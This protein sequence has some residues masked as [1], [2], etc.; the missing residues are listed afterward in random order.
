VTPDIVPSDGFS[1]ADLLKKASTAEEARQAADGL[2]AAKLSEF[3]P[4]PLPST[5]ADATVWEAGPSSIAELVL[6]PSQIR[7]L[8]ASSLLP[9]SPGSTPAH[10]YRVVL[11]RAGRGW[12]KNFCAAHIVNRVAQEAARLVAEGKLQR[13]SARILLVGRSADDVNSAMIGGPT[14]LVATS[15]E[16]FRAEHQPGNRRVV[17]GGG[18]VE[19]VARSAQEPEGVR[20]Q[21]AIFCWAD[22]LCAWGAGLEAT[23]ANL[24]LA[25]RIGPAP[26]VLV[27]TT[28]KPSDFLRGL[29]V[30]S[31]TLDI[32]R[33][34]SDNVLALGQKYVADK[35]AEY[36]GWRAAQELDALVLDGAAQ[37]FFPR[38]DVRFLESVPE[39]TR[40]VRAWDLAATPPSY[41]NPDP[42]WTCGIKLGRTTA[43]QFV[44][45]HAVMLRDRP[46]AVEQ[47]ILR[48]A[49][50]DGRGVPIV[51]P[52]DPGQAGVAQVADLVAK[53]AG[54]V[55]RTERPTGS[56]ATRAEP[57]SIQWCHGN[58]K[59]IRASWND[60]YL[61]QMEAFSSD[62]S[63][64]HDDA[65][66]A[67]A[68][69]FNFLAAERPQP[70][71]IGGR[72]GGQ[73]RTDAGMPTRRRSRW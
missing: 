2:R 16:W 29:L 41:T 13:E 56:K 67:S 60:D 69:A 11:L 22:E 35:Y 64:G 62:G 70:N 6:R 31:D 73:R 63:P 5:Y 26:R 10:S 39:I 1:I 46:A 53:L 15:P 44:I 58:V 54:H 3:C 24:D 40:V 27:S 49:E 61:R 9:P 42:D 18:L 65:P 4:A 17:W 23:W 34:M 21:N 45:L 51:L 38:A 59:M 19:A 57:L 8:R 12:G 37:S 47:A 55:V 66:D 43:G 48:E 71:W 20:G 50:I 28:P 30:K 33:P 7:A 68:T 14:G 32:H 72:V 52:Q 36:S 25:T